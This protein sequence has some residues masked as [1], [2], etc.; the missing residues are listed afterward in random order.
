MAENHRFFG[1]GCDSVNKLCIQNRA[2]SIVLSHKPSS[3][4]SLMLIVHKI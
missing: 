4:L 1:F 3:D 2:V